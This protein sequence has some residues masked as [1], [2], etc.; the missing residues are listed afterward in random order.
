MWEHPL[1]NP[2][3]FPLD[4]DY[5][6]DYY[7]TYIKMIKKPMDMTTLYNK[8]NQNQYQ[9][10]TDFS[11][12]MLLIFSNAKEFNEK[13]SDLYESAAQL[14]EYY[15]ILVEPIKKANLESREFKVKFIKIV[16]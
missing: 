1:A 7:D 14:E 9:T 2:F 6:G 16:G 3:N 13:G 4:K 15:K 10:L 11:K 8:L 5:L 12:E